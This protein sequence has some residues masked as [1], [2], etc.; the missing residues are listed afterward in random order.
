MIAKPVALT[1]GTILRER[2]TARAMT[3]EQLAEAAGIHP[4]YVG[5]LE[6]GLRQPTLDVLLRLAQAL[7]LPPGEFVTETAR[8]L[9][10]A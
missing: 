3:Q 9:S 2:R 6:R 1:F 4:K 8:R 10:A 7:D 5:M